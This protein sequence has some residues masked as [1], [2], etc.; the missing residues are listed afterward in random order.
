MKSGFPKWVCVLSAAVPLSQC[1]PGRSAAYHANMEDLRNQVK[2]GEDIHTATK[3][4]K[5]RY[6]I[7][8]EPYD[9]T[10][11][12]RELHSDVDFGLPVTFFESLA[13]AAD[14]RLPFDD[15]EPISAILKARSNGTI[16]AIE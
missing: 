10:G 15:N 3:R 16:V 1:A 2:I 5:G 4:I 9:P 13:Y 7:V 14:T 11:L 12:G 8:T 6:H